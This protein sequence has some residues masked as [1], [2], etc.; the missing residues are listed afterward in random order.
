[1]SPMGDA[2]SISKQ[3]KELSR[4]KAHCERAKLSPTPLD[5][6]HKTCKP[7]H[8]KG[9]EISLEAG[10]HKTRPTQYK[11]QQGNIDWSIETPRSLSLSHTQQTLSHPL[12]FIVAFSF[13]L[14]SNSEYAIL[15]GCGRARFRMPSLLLLRILPETK[16]F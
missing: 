7:G 1:M 4:Q 13:C 5:I 15:R 10:E 6:R 3:F 12:L 9:V 2:G 16:I 14:C 11:L 8:G